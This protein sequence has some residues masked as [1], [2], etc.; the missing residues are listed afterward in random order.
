MKSPCSFHKVAI[1]DFGTGSSPISYLI[2]IPDNTVKQIRYLQ[3]TLKALEKSIVDL[4]Q[5]FKY[6]VITEGVEA[7]EQRNEV[8]NLGCTI[9]EVIIANCFLIKLLINI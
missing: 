5:T 4:Q 3:K 1:D 6:M 7:K 2:N 9:Y 8:T